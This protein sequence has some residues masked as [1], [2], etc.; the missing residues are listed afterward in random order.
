MRIIS[1]IGILTAGLLLSQCSLPT[2]K[3]GLKDT[4]KSTD[5]NSLKQLLTTGTSAKCSYEMDGVKVETLVKDKKMRVKGIGFGELGTGEMINDGETIYVW[6]NENK[7]GIK[8]NIEELKSLGEDEQ[9]QKE[10]FDQLP[11]G[12][13]DPQKWADE[14]EQKYQVSCE[15]ISVDDAEFVVPTEVNF[16]DLTELIQNIKQFAPTEGSQVPSAQDL[17]S[18]KQNLEKMNI[19]DGVDNGG[20]EE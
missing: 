8:Y 6:N 15:K 3:L 18:I 11:Q 20:T 4:V 2:S 14:M 7:S 16:Q 19:G 13:D 5:S 10:R 1:T 12:V 9:Q 17:D